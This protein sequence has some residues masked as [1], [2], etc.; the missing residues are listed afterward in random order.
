MFLSVGNP[1]SEVVE[2]L[3]DGLLFRHQGCFGRGL[4]D[5]IPSVIYVMRWHF[6]TYSH[7][8]RAVGVPFRLDPD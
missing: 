5:S 1:P 8:D 6:Q 4:T 2:N 7:V 3:L